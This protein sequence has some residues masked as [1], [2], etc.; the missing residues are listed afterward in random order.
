LIRKN[1]SS[2]QCLDQKS[3]VLITRIF[4]FSRS[5]YGKKTSRST[6]QRVDERENQIIKDEVRVII[7]RK[8]YFVNNK[9][10][11]RTIILYL[12]LLL[13]FAFFLFISEALVHII[14]DEILE[15]LKI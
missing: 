5:F 15:Y 7:G 14:K 2:L 10:D 13:S 8:K 11:K 1:A 3:K 4:R 6:Q 12:L 9:N